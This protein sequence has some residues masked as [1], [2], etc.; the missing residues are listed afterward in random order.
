MPD[1]DRF[2]RALRGP[3]RFP[4]RIAAGGARAELV[5]EKL[6]SSCLGLLTE[7]GVGCARKV[8]TALDAALAHSSMPLF[9]GEPEGTAFQRLLRGLDLIAAEHQFDEFA[10]GCGRAASRC[11]FELEHS[12]QHISDEHLERMFARE[13]MAEV[14]GRHF[15]PI[16]RDRLAE[17]TGRD[18]AAQRAWEDQVMQCISENIQN[19]S[20]ALFADDTQRRTQRRIRQAPVPSFDWNRLNKPLHVLGAQQWRTP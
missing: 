19:F 3:W 10:Q 11:F 4:Y 1:G 5:A 20:R 8:L 7:D 16:V 18:A 12:H 17:N 6:A 15:F 9:Y 14:L 13:V 2:E